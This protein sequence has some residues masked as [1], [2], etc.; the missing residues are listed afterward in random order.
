[1]VTKVASNGKTKTV[2]YVPQNGVLV[3]WAPSSETLLAL[4]AERAPIIPA[5]LWTNYGSFDLLRASEGYAGDNKVLDYEVC[6]I[7]S[8]SDGEV[9]EEWYNPRFGPI[10]LKSIEKTEEGIIITEATSI[11]LRE[12]LLSEV[13]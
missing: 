10:V 13:E 2:R 11:E 7:R 4:G 12:V 9:Y 6:I 1:M 5:T 8:E 3:E